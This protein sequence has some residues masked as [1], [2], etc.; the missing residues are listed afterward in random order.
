MVRADEAT[1]DAALGYNDLSSSSDEEGC[2]GGMDS[3]H[4]RVCIVQ[5][6]S[7][8]LMDF[9]PISCCQ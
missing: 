6:A 9:S 1:D 2:D 3:L 8:I 7:E 4:S 5:H